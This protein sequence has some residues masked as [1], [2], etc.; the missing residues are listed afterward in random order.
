[1]TFGGHALRSNTGI[2]LQGCLL[3]GH[4]WGHV[5][6]SLPTSLSLS[7]KRWP[8]ST[9][10]CADCCVSEKCTRLLLYCVVA[11]DRVQ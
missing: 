10:F 9:W 4:S 6:T 3:R 5:L 2:V 8:G 11:P 7:S 1:M